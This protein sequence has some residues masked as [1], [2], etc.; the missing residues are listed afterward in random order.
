[1][2]IITSVSLF[3]AFTS[4]IEHFQLDESWNQGESSFFFILLTPGGFQDLKTFTELEQLCNML[5][6]FSPTL[7]HNVFCF[8]YLD[9]V[10]ERQCWDWISHRLCFF[11]HFW[12]ALQSKREGKLA[13]TKLNQ[14]KSESLH[15]AKLNNSITARNTR[16]PVCLFSG[17]CFLR[18]R[19]SDPASSN[20]T[21]CLIFKELPGSTLQTQEDQM[22]RVSILF[23]WHKPQ[24]PSDCCLDS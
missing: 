11:F 13:L 17:C 9:S 20:F 22:V 16:L 5:F 2:H 21:G 3:K 15:R 14:A 12:H 8:L 10:G 18:V 24:N 6:I 7:T 4:V 23:D 1:M 19:I